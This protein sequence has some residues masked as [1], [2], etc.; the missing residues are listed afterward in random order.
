MFGS[1]VSWKA[2][3]APSLTH[4]LALCRN[5]GCK[6][7]NRI[8]RRL[9]RGDLVLARSARRHNLRRRGAYLARPSPQRN[10]L[11]L[12]SVVAL[13]LLDPLAPPLE[14]PSTRLASNNNSNHSSNPSNNL[15]NNPSSSQQGLGSVR[16]VK[17][18]HSN[19]LASALGVLVPH[20]RS[21]KPAVSLVPLLSV[22]SPPPP[23]LVRVSLSNLVLSN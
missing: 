1:F 5:L 19:Q 4:A 2:T 9:L 12:R 21:N 6:I 17:L 20:S 14:Q 18:S 16:L 11:N 7:I 8:A 3:P 13:V 10:P 22:K 23:V 15:S